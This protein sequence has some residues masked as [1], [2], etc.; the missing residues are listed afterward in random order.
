MP[1]V[2]NEEL[3]GIVTSRDFRYQENHSIKGNLIV[4]KER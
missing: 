4:L 1:V 3:V 2:D